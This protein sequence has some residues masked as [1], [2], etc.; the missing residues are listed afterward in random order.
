[1]TIVCRLMSMNVS[2]NRSLIFFLMLVSTSNIM[3]IDTVRPAKV[4]YVLNLEMLILLEA[5]Y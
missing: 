3:Q 5:I 2:L 1:M 4:S